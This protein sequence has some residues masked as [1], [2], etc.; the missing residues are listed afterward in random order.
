LLCECRD[1][2]ACL[3]IS[4]LGCAGEEIRVLRLARLDWLRDAPLPR[5]LPRQRKELELGQEPDHRLAIG[6]A[7]D[8]RTSI[9]RHR[10]IALDRD[11]LARETRTVRLGQQCLARTLRRDIGGPLENGVQVS[12]LRE[13]LLG[14]LL[15]N[16]LYSGNV[17]RGITN[18]S[19][20]VDHL[21]RLDTQTLRCVPLI[22]PGFIHRRWTAATRVEQR[23]ARADQLVEILVAGNNHYLESPLR[24]SGR[25]RAD[26]VVGFV[27]LDRDERNTEGFQQ[28]ADALEGSVEV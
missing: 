20:E 23:N 25:Q 21:P 10:D 14:S 6:F 24:P 7:R 2:G 26:Y 3:Q 4:A 18:Q 5:Q 16:P 19:E 17:V 27:A 9:E 1:G 28:V 22:H 12:V 13:Q 8:Q 11:Q 15:A